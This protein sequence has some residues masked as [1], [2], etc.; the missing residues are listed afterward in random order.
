MRTFH[1]S[2]W[3][4]F[5]PFLALATNFSVPFLTEKFGNHDVVEDRENMSGDYL[6]WLESSIGANADPDYTEL[7]VDELVELMKEVPLQTDEWV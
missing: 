6:Q 3:L 4:Y 5:I 7:T 1:T 2:V